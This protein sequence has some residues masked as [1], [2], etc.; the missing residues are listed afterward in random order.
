MNSDTRP[1]SDKSTS[2]STFFQ[3]AGAGAAVRWPEFVRE[4]STFILGCIRRFTTDPDERM[5]MYAHVCV[6]LRADDCRRLKQFRGHG[7]E[8]DCKFTTWLATVT[9]N[10]CREWIRVNRG[11]RRF[12]KAIERLTAKHALV[13]KHRYWNGYTSEQILEVLKPMGL[14]SS[15]A[16]VDTILGGDR[17]GA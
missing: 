16:D 5:D 15:V 4:Y 9:L 7:D 13:F 10:L 11:R 8:G 17:V 1:L 2:T 3:S 12:Y 6:R 14:A